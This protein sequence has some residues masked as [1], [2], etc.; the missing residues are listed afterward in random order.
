MLVYEVNDYVLEVLIFVR[1][2]GF[3]VLDVKG[4]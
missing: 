2:T 4:H 1:L 3:L